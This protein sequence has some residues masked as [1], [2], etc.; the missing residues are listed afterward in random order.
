MNP[1]NPLLNLSCFS[2]ILSKNR[3]TRTSFGGFLLMFNHIV[4]LVIFDTL[5][6]EG[7][8][9]YFLFSYFLVIRIIFYL[10]ICISDNCDLFVENVLW[11]WD[12]FW[13]VINFYLIFETEQCQLISWQFLLK[14]RMSLATSTRIN[15]Q[16]M[17]II[18]LSRHITGTTPYKYK[19]GAKFSRS[20]FQSVRTA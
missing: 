3:S 10:W 1:H 18:P 7:S 9:C 8:S 13:I 5:S 17:N 6:R 19:L 2:Q 12:Y 15:I 4:F 11:K 16:W 20:V 14:F